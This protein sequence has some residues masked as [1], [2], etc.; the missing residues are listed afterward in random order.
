MSI[1]LR[2]PDFSF[3]KRKPK[4]LKHVFF[5]TLDPSSSLDD[6]WLIVHSNLYLSSLEAF[7]IIIWRH[8]E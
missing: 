8:F 6:F 1:Q 2:L 7:H 5:Q 3:N 4:K